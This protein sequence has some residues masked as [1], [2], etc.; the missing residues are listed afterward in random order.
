MRKK[1]ERINKL[2]INLIAQKI[3]DDS[4]RFHT[5]NLKIN[6]LRFAVSVIVFSVLDWGEH[7][8]MKMDF[9]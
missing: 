4:I 6:R 3:I 9:S 7:E 2:T 5:N 1:N 8:K